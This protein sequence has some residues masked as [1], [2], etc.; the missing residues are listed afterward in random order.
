MSR[1]HIL[2]ID[3]GQKPGVAQFEIET[4]I[5]G[6]PDVVRLVRVSHKIEPWCYAAPKWDVLAVELQWHHAGGKA[7][8]QSL[9][10][11]AFRAGFTLGNI[12]A[13]RRLAL[14]PRI[15]R[16]EGNNASKEQVQ[17]RIARDLTAAERQ[18]FSDIPKARHG[19]VLD[20][21]GIGR[22]ALALAPNTT[23]YDWSI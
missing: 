4:D 20:A 3:P 21:I 6:G 7:S 12:P 19:D 1:T 11:L 22:A 16:G 15:W 23:Q 8:V 10:S 9:L 18:L 5:G 14:P 17:K 2:A 13:A